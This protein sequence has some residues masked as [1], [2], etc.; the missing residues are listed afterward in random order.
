MEAYSQTAKEARL[1]VLDLIYSAQTS[2]I[3]SNFSCIDI[4]TVLFEKIDLDKDRF[5]LS[6]GWK[7][8]SLYYFLWKK[9][10]ITEDELNSYCKDGS[11][12]IGLTEPIHPDIPFSG[13]SMGMGLPA[14]V[15]FALAKKIKKEEGTIYVLESDGAI[16]GGLIW[17]S[18]N[19]AEKYKLDNLVVFIDWNKFCAMGDTAEITNL[20]PEKVTDIFKSFG[21]CVYRIDGHNFNEIE[22]VLK[23]KKEEEKPTVIISETIKGK[24]V[25][26][27]EGDNLWHYWHI[28]KKVYEEALAELH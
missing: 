13:G 7:A 28:D 9:G 15:G 25:K 11:K 6:A 14:A 5:I 16:S 24:G 18:A 20:D 19:L 27:F 2:H 3:G 1:K 8:A 17:E 22:A 21:W 4:L 10:R 23:T 12:W 26:K